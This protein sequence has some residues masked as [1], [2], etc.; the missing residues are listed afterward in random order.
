M[1]GYIHLE[2]LLQVVEKLRTNDYVILT[3]I[4]CSNWIEFTKYKDCLKVRELKELRKDIPNFKFIH[5]PYISTSQLIQTVQLKTGETFTRFV[6]SDE[7]DFKE[8]IIKHKEFENEV[9]RKSKQLIKEVE[10]LFPNLSDSKILFKFRNLVK[11]IEQ[12]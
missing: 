6:E 8:T 5:I 3:E 2:N 1:N 10:K 11:S 9:L 7:T 12:V 4:E